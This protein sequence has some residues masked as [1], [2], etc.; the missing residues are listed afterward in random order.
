VDDGAGSSADFGHEYSDHALDSRAAAEALAGLDDDQAIT[1]NVAGNMRTGQFSPT[2]VVAGV[3]VPG[4]TITEMNRYIRH[5]QGTTRRDTSVTIFCEP[6][7]SG[8]AE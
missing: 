5:P 6:L 1:V 4:G 3:E 8:G 2:Q 7:R